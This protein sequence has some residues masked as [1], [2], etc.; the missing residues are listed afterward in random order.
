MNIIEWIFSNPLILFILIGILSSLF[1]K[2]GEEQ[3]QT[4]K[5]K[6]Q[7]QQQAGQQTQPQTAKEE[8]EYNWDFDIFG[9]KAEELEKQLR[10]TF[11]PPKEEKVMK[12]EPIREQPIVERVLD[13]EIPKDSPILQTE[14]QTSEGKVYK[15]HHEISRKQVVNGVIWSEILGQPR[16]QKPYRPPHLQRRGR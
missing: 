13:F 6:P 5:P 3:Q 10:D 16:A 8:K 9:E 11:Y 15:H 2:K 7:R 1:R 14:L 12:V 4:N